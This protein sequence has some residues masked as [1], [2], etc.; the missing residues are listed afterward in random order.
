MLNS[1]YSQK[2][3]ELLD[4]CSSGQRKN[5]LQVS[6]NLFYSI[7]CQRIV[8]DYYSASIIIST[9]SGQHNII[10]NLQLLSCVILRSALIKWRAF[11]LLPQLHLMGYLHF[12][13]FVISFTINFFSANQ[14]SFVLEMIE[15]LWIP[16]NPWVLKTQW[17]DCRISSYK[18]LSHG[19][20]WLL[21]WW[22][23]DKHYI[24][25]PT[26]TKLGLPLLLFSLGRTVFQSLWGLWQLHWTLL[27]ALNLTKTQWTIVFA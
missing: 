24:F 20:H 12:W 15:K 17:W 26:L 22:F 21:C 23:C 11:L 8:N 10:Q 6:L 1:Q 3:G 5:F 25:C 18:S 14:S 13:Q 16:F 19:L 2:F 27:L 7:C 9:N 4:Q